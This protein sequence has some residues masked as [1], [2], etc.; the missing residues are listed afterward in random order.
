VL[1][2]RGELFAVED[3]EERAKAGEEDV[4]LRVSFSGGP[5]ENLEKGMQRFA[6]TLV[7]FFE[8]KT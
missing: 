7:K 8:V 4:F 1:F 3:D 2:R 5:K 6:T